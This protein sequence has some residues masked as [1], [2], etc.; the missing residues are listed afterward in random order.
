MPCVAV[1][2]IQWILLFLEALQIIS[3]SNI[4]PNPV[5][6][7][8]TISSIIQ[9]IAIFLKNTSNDSNV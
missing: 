9:N 8:T 6:K 3:K 5:K 4:M 2:P 7:N 1:N